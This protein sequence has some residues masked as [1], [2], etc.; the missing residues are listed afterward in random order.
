[1]AGGRDC[2]G[3]AMLYPVPKRTEEPAAIVLPTKESPLPETLPGSQQ[4]QQVGVREGVLQCQIW[5]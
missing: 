1:M 5:T 3:E 2:T 4:L